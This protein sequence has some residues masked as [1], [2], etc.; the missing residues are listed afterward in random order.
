MSSRCE[1]IMPETHRLADVGFHAG[2]VTVQHRAGVE[3]QAARLVRM[4][5]PVELDGGITRFLAD[6]TFAALTGRDDAGRLWVTPLTGSP[7]FL[8]VTS[9][10]T[11][12][13]SVA[14]PVGDP[15]HG[16][17][18]PAHHAFPCVPWAGRA[19]TCRV[20]PRTAGACASSRRATRAP[21][22]VSR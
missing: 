15:L 14:L 1:Q 19:A 5:E 17:G 7:G 12:E 13:V 11:L 18:R 3:A 21:S 2:E 6:R 10:T 4:L 8:T 9:L 22:A 20:R 16:P